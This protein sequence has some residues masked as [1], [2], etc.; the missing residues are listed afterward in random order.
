MSNH[1]F[2]SLSVI[3]R[4]LLYSDSSG[5]SAGKESTS[6]AEDPGLTSG[7]GRSP[8]GGHG[9][10]LQYSCW[11]IPMDRGAW[12]AIVH[13]V[14]KNLA[15]LSIST[16]QNFTQE[17]LAKGLHFKKILRKGILTIT[18]KLTKGLVTEWTSDYGCDFYGFCLECYWFWSVFSSYRE[19]HPLKSI[20]IYSS[21][22]NS[23]CEWN[24]SISFSFLS[25]PSRNWKLLG[26]EQLYQ[27]IGKNCLLACA[28]ISMFWGLLEEKTH[29]GRALWHTFSL[30][31]LALRPFGNSVWDFWGLTPQLVWR[32]VHGQS[33]GPV[34]QAN[35]FW[36]A[37]FCG[38]ERTMLCFN[39]C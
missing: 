20:L 25:G 39:G 3:E 36:L 5:S 9:N 22:V 2:L 12:W 33:T 4:K 38:F 11:R 17:A 34:L 24:W 7:L 37:V 16:A 13:G 29:Q 35:S 15:W 30:A 1:A 18:K 23:T 31:F 19:A 28:G 8:G 21:L 26:S 14:T 6:N 10:P 32:L 27:G